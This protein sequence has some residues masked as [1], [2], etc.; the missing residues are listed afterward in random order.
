MTASD[1]I[2]IVLILGELSYQSDCPYHVRFRTTDD[3]CL[4]TMLGVIHMEIY[5]ASCSVLGSP[6]SDDLDI[7][8]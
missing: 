7:L 8:V 2:F 6:L 1:A 4:F 5:V 3:L